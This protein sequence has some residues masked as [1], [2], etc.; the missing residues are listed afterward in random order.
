MEQIS[1]NLRLCLRFLLAVLGHYFLVGGGAIIGAILLLYPELYQG[2]R[3]SGWWLLIALFFVAV[4]LAW[5][6]QH[7]KADDEHNKVLALEKKLN[8][9]MQISGGRS[10]DKCFIWGGEIFYFRAKL[11]SLGLDHIREVEAHITEIRREGKP[12]E[13]FEE[14]QLM[15]HPGC[16]TLPLLKQGVYRIY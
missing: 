2:V 11:E 5:R 13:L 9:K 15:M 14:A 10:V 3:V 16:R 1:E 12:V 8:P 7:Q 6:D 4:F